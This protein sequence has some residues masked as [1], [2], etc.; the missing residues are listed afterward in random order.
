M[1][2]LLYTSYFIFGTI[3]GSF[4]NVVILRYNTGF[5]L[6]GRS[7][8]LSCGKKLQWYE[9]IPILSFL[10]L[11]G[12]C[13]GCNSK[14]SWQYPL[15]EFTTGMLFMFTLVNFLDI[16]NPQSYILT[17]L[18]LV[19]VALLIVI[20]VYDIRHTIIPD[21]LVYTFAAVSFIQLFFNYS[22]YEL[23]HYP[24]ILDLL[25]GPL[26][27]LPFF[28]LWF[29]SRGRWMG[30]GDAKLAVGIGFLLG[31]KEGISA[32]VI[33]FW[34]GAFVSL[35][36]IMLQKIL[37]STVIQKTGL[38]LRLKQ[39]TIKSEIPFAPYLIIGTF[40]AVF[41]SLDVFNLYELFGL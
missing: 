2:W 5:A 23:T 1:D 31:L 40:L 15:V 28:L 16:Y 27:F 10:F 22:F 20:A 14:I 12:K 34:I 17:V 9:L 38:F 24:H 7:G 26:L 19:I 32:L 13:A 21:G 41:Y 25:A 3:I 35:V 33:A 37:S 36:Y 29:V 18:Y 6:T 11:R 8:C 39:L 4:L 30:F